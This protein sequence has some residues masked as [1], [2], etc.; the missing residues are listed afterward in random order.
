MGKDVDGNVS[1]NYECCVLNKDVC[2]CGEGRCG[3]NTVQL[4]KLMI[5]RGEKYA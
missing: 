4:K 5:R 2:K 1:K 3:K